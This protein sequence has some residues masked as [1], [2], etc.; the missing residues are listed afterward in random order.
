MKTPDQLPPM[1]PPLTPDQLDQNDDWD[2]VDQASI[3]SFPASDPPAWGSSHA[4]ASQDT[5]CPPELLPQGLSKYVIGAAI[6]AGTLLAIG[7]IVVAIRY[8]RR[9]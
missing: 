5:V 8:L 7:A 3:E 1:G 9:P 2:H 6:G 4:A